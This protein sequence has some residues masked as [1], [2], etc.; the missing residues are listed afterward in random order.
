[1]AS[2]EVDG[3]KLERRL[4]ARTSVFVFGG[5]VP[6]PITEDFNYH[7]AGVGAGYEFRGAA[8]NHGGGVFTQ[9]FDGAIDRVYLTQQSYLRLTRDLS[10]AAFVL[11]DLLQRDGLV[12]LAGDRHLDLTS[13]YGLLRYR[14]FK[15]LDVSVSV[16]HNHTILP[17]RWWY[18]WLNQRRRAIGF[19]L[20]GLD[21][22]G[23]RVTSVRGTANFEVTRTLVPYV[24]VR[25]DWRHTPDTADG[26]ETRAGLKWRPAWAFADLSYA[27][28][29]HF[30]TQ[31]HL[32]AL[33]LG[34][35][36]VY[37]GGEAGLMVLR[38][39]PDAG[40]P[41]SLAYDVNAVAWVALPR[42]FGTRHRV[43]LLLEY[44]AFI[45]PAITMHIGM[46]QLGYRF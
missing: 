13:A 31:S 27:W 16:N 3:L 8:S 4:G 32:A 39:R 9:L 37:W 14:P 34:A 38:A 33:R 43:H 11:V 35:D 22:V 24:Q 28:R 17:G 7:F 5:L 6:D 26:Y 21:P 45:E 29:D 36:K 1:V 18:D 19:V 2:A 23:T 15:W 12:A 40:G 44:Q 25:G 30:G 42:L 41:A 10:A 20:D 46:V